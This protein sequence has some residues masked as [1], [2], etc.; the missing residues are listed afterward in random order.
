MTTDNHFDLVILGG[1]PAG[2]SAAF[3]AAAKGIKT[4]LVEPGFLGG[5]CLNVGCIPTK[6]LLGASASAPLFAVQKKYKVAAGD[7]HFDLPALQTR[8]DRF[9]KGSRQALEKNLAE[10]GV[11]VI[12]GKGRLTGPNTIST[13]DTNPE[14]TF[15]SCIIATGSL[16]AS[17]PDLAPD[18][19]SIRSSS[20][21]LALTECP[22]SLII[23]GGG[24]IGIELG[25]IYHRLG[26]RITLVDAAERILPAEDPE[27]SQTLH[28]YLARDGWKIHTGRK[29]ASFT[30]LDGESVLRF[31]DGE[32]L[33][34]GAGLIAVGRKSGA[35]ALGLESAGIATTEKGFIATDENLRCAENIYAVGDVNGRVLLAHAADNQARYALRRVAGEATGPYTPLPMPSCVY[36]TMEVMRVGPTLAELKAEGGAVSTSRA[37]FAAN[38]IAQ[39]YGHTQGFVRMLWQGDMLRAVSA[40]GHGA[41]HLVSAAAL[42]VGREYVAGGTPPIIFAHPTLDEILESA[43]LASREYVE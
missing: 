41:S 18:G 39:S 40:V 19:Q 16:P 31:E 15:G 27:I 13:G 42:L 21:L 23:V 37:P 29:I 38:A 20:G 3:G 8:K 30:T 36:G 11:A 28:A 4:A 5:A 43:I 26:S 34:A 12:K 25:E 14:L 17:F 9:I 32:E 10:A 22:Q 33:R 35:S 24:A 7:V 1:G 2:T 6:F